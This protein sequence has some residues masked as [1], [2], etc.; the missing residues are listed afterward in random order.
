LLFD[1]S[2][3]PIWIHDAVGLAVLEVDAPAAEHYGYSRDEFLRMRITAI[4]PA[5]ELPKL[6]E[7]VGGGRCRSRNGSARHR[8]NTGAARRLKPR[9]CRDHARASERPERSDPAVIRLGARALRRDRPAAVDATAN[10][11]RAAATGPRANNR[12]RIRFSL[13]PGCP[14]RLA[15]CSP[16]TR[17]GLDCR[18]GIRMVAVGGI[19]PPTRGL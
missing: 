17:P 6:Q 10:A 5:A 14:G 8:V 16:G 19:E 9:R 13:V 11:P 18:T 7:V 2:A 1:N 4:R 12:R 3:L 15:P